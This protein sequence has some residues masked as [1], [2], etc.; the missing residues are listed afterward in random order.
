MFSTLGIFVDNNG[1]RSRV[2]EL[3]WPA[4]PHAAS[5]HNP[6]QGHSQ[7]QGQGQNPYLI[8]WA[9]NCAFVYDIYSGDWLQTLPL[10][11]VKP[12]CLDGSLGLSYIS[13]VPRLIY[14]HDMQQ[15]Q[16]YQTSNACTFLLYITH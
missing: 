6:P 4:I 2:Q 8:I 12:L 1:R 14:F 15:V 3:M 7:G 5:Y 16:N 9:E 13:D 10:K 11:R